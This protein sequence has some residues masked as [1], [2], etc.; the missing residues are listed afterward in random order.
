MLPMP[1]TIERAS[2]AGRARARKRAHQA[3][4]TG[5]GPEQLRKLDELLEIDPTTG[6]TRLTALRTIPANPKPD[7]VREIVDRLKTVRALGIPAHAGGFI[8]PE[9]LRNLVREGRLSPAYLIDRYTVARRR[10]T[11]R[12]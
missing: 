12:C 9:R 1:A 6:L 10:A 3:L 7:H 5:L 2:V 11:T 4:L 8:H